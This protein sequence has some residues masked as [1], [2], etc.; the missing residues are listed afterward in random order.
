MKILSD[1][2]ILLIISGGIAAY[3]SLELIRLLQKKGARVRCILSHGGA[4]FITPLSVSAISGGPVFTDLWS[5]KNESEIGHVTLG[6]ECDLMVV[7]PASANLMGKFA[8]GLADDLAS[9]TLLASDKPV[10]FAPA[11]N[12]QMWSKTQVKENVETLEKYGHKMIGPENGD[13][14]CGEEGSG[15]MSEPEQIIS[16]IETFFRPRPLEGRRAIVTSGPTF[17]AIDPVRFIGNRSSGKQGHAIATALSGAGANV[18]LISGPVNLPDPENVNVVHVESAKEMHESVMNSLPAD[19]A[20]CAAA[21]ADWRPS[22]IKNAKIKKTAADNPPEIQMEENPDILALLSSCKKRPELVI[23]FAAETENL[24]EQAKLKLEKKKCDVIVANLVGP[25][26][27]GVFGSEE[28]HVYY[29]TDAF[30]EEWQK[31]R[32]N[33]IAEKLVAKITEHLNRHG[34]GEQ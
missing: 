29:I 10:L 25:S 9:A 15:R 3:K 17:E 21:V 20:V 8:N 24:I 27:A 13:T 18:T 19:I 2:I 28:N 5:L 16:E 23:G 33:S 6:R 4:K 1:K 34:N 32:K 30:M 11:M 22:N 7:A 14:A 31:S 12:P 26:E